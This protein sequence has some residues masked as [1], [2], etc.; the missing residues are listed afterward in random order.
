MTMEPSDR[1]RGLGGGAVL[2]LWIV[3]ASSVVGACLGAVSLNLQA[4]GL[5]LIA[6]SIAF[7]GIAKVIFGK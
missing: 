4:A 2:A 1:V 6:A 3:G 7:S 5:C